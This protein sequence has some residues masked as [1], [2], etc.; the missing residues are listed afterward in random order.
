[1]IEQE[2]DLEQPVVVHDEPCPE[3]AADQRGTRVETPFDQAF[4]DAI[5]ARWRHGERT[6]AGGEEVWWVVAGN[7]EEVEELVIEHFG[8]CRVV[9]ADGSETLRDRTGDYDQGA[10][11]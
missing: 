1:M 2:E 5:K 3:Q 6:W 10:L 7:E 9:H 8:G 11:F 4:V